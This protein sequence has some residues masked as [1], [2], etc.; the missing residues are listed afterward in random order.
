[1]GLLMSHK[2]DKQHKKNGVSKVDEQAYIWIIN[3]TS[4]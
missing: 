4:Q 2:I 3:I 1:M